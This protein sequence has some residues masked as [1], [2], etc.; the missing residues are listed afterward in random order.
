MLLRAIVVALFVWSCGPARSQPDTVRPRPVGGSTGARIPDSVRVSDSDA[1]EVLRSHEASR[2][3][4]VGAVRRRHMRDTLSAQRHLWEERRPGAYVIRVL[5]IGG[6]IDVRTGPRRAGQLL[7]DQLVVRDTTVVRREPV[8]IS[9]AYEQRCPLA[10]RVDDL[11]ADVARTLADS[12]AHLAS[13]QYDPAYGFP[14]SYFVVRGLSHGRRVMVE[15]F[16]PV[17]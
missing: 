4:P 5:D 16:A 7:R 14:R 6:C 2:A 1:V 17:P 10:W 9:A 11:F 8:P 15:S 13:V 3:D 12:T